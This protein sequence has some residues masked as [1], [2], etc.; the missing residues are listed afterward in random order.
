M[1]EVRLAAVT[2]ALEILFTKIKF[3]PLDVWWLVDQTEKKGSTLH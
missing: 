1:R 3:F 2:F